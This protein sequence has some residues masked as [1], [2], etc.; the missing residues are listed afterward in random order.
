MKKC[1]C[2][3]EQDLLETPGSR[4]NHRF[5]RGHNSRVPGARTVP[6]KK[7]PVEQR[8]WERVHQTSACWL[9]L[10]TIGSDGYGRMLRDGKFDLVHRISWTLA[11]RTLAPDQHLHHTCH[12]RACVR[13]DHLQA[14]SGSEHQHAHEH[15]SGDAHWTRR[16]PERVNVAAM[17]AARWP[18][19]M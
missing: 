3:C 5:I 2:G 9:W 1:Q 12:N 10:G 18:K 17:K 8:F 16:M 19:K 6:R 11:G 4:K 13:P 14:L 15:P 7:R